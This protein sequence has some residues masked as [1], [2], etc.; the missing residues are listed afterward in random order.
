MR[1]APA[2]LLV[3]FVSLLVSV[4]LVAQRGGGGR[5]GD[6]NTA[7]TFESAEDRL[8]FP[9]P[10]DVSLY[11]SERPGRYKDLFSKGYVAYLV[12][13]FGKD[14]RIG[15]RRMPGVSESDLKGLLQTLETKPPQAAQPGFKKMSVGTIKVG[16]NN[17]KDAVDFVYSAL[18]KDV[19]MTTRQVS[20]VHRGKGFTFSC[21]AAAKEFDAANKNTFDRLLASIRFD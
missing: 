19:E 1:R 15:V 3:V 2:L 13:Q 8:T 10:P 4:S 5:R 14:I 16:T 12:N 6:A 21:I 17:D 20:F 11:T 7:A 18:D 9:V